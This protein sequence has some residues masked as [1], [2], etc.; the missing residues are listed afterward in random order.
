[1]EWA[2]TL[3]VEVDEATILRLRRNLV[4]SLRGDGI[5]VQTVTVEKWMFDAATKQPVQETMGP[6]ASW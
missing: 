5:E 3:F 1:M 6:R 2:M 4:D